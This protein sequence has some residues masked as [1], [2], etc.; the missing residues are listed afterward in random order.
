MV[1]VASNKEDET[2][3]DTRAVHMT[4][5]EQETTIRWSLDRKNDPLLYLYSAQPVFKRKMDKLGAVPSKTDRVRGVEV[6]WFW[7]LPIDAWRVS[8]RPKRHGPPSEAQIA[9]GKLV[10][11]KARKA[12]EY[13]KNKGLDE[14][15]PAVEGDISSKAANAPRHS[16]EGGES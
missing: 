7:E 8:I 12:R 3:E 2:P 14:S 9:A 15:S 5:Y 11:E 6:A 13:R 4:L 16:A 10:A 1:A